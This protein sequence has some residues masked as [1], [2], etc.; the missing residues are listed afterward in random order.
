[1]EIQAEQQA[2]DCVLLPS[3]HWPQWGQNTLRTFCAKVFQAFPSPQVLY[4]Y[5]VCTNKNGKTAARHMTFPTDHS[6][7]TK[8]RHGGEECHDHHAMDVA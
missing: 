8:G 6:W 4:V 7:Q 3:F 2:Q 5:D 1:M